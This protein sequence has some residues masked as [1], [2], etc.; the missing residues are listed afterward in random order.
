MNKAMSNLTSPLLSLRG[1]SKVFTETGSR[2]EL[3]RDL[4]FDLDAGAFVSITGASGAGKSTLLHILGLLE[5]PT[6]GDVRF[7][8]EAISAFGDT[9]LSRIRNRDIGFVF[10][11]HHLLPDLTALENVLLPLRIAGRLDAASRARATELLADVGLGDRLDHVPARLSGGER[12]RA[13]VARALVNKP[14]VLLCDEPSGN[15]DT[16]TSEQLH[17]MLAALNRDHGVAILVVTHDAALA[18]LAARPL[19]LRDG[20]LQAAG[21]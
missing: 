20:R 4:D 15:L 17:G 5:R 1:A 2:I 13:A 19:A 3:F 11:F 10:Q 14:S 9:Q 12:Q 6:S 18:R 8:G 7:R 16:R 21:A